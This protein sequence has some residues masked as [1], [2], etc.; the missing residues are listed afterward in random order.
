VDDAGLVRG[1]EGV[2][3]LHGHVER[4]FQRHPFAVEARAQSLAVNELH[5]DEVRAVFVADFVDGDDVRV[6]QGGGGRRLA[7][8]AAQSVF[9]LREFG[10]EDFER[11]GTAQ[12]RV[13]REIDFAHPAR[14][15]LRADFVTAETCAGGD[16]HD[17]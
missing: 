2:G 4:L 10:G 11:G 15:E 14:A 8:E 17:Q 6:V 5:R 3:H 1:R 7:L 16:G 9:A 13:L 12:V